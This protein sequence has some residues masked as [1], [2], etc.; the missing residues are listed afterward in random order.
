MT[1]IED[2]C[3]VHTRL[4][5]LIGWGPSADES[6]HGVEE[7]SQLVELESQERCLD[8]IVIFEQVAKGHF[9]FD[10]LQLLELVLLLLLNSAI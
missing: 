2:W 3:V 7:V 10:A 8:E 5:W 9:F 1:L 6:R 4:E